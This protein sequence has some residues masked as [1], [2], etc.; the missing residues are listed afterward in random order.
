MKKVK[1][2]YLELCVKVQGSFEELKNDETGSLGVK[3]IAGTLAFIV[4]IAAIATLVS[5]DTTLMGGWIGDIWDFMTE[6]LDD[7][8]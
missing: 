3:E 1:E 7:M 4:V 8:F 6:A 2:M 5:S